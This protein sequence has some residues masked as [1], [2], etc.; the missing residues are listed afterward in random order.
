[1][2]FQKNKFSKTD[3]TKPKRQKTLPEY[4]VRKNQHQYS[5]ITSSIATMRQSSVGSDNQEYNDNAKQGPQQFNKR[6][7]QL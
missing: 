1:M 2:S 6:N 3:K 5:I 7:R 4:T